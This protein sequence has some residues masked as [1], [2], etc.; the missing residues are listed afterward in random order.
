MFDLRYHVASLAAVF[1]ALI[2]GILVGVGIASQ[3]SVS[4]SDRQLL[5]QR[6]SDLQ[7]D[8]ESAR[9]DADLLRRQQAAGT[10]YIEESYPAVMSG[11]LRGVP[12]ALLF[13]GPVDSKLRSAVVQ[14]LG[15]AN[16][17]PLARMRALQLPIDTAAV[18][19]AIPSDAGSPKLEEVGRRLGREFVGRGETPFWDALAPVIVQDSQGPS[20][21]E[22]DAIVVVQTVPLDGAPTT[23]LVSGVYA[24]LAGSGVPVVGVARTDQQP[25]RIAVYR[26]RGLSSVDAVD[27]QV[28]RVALAVLLAGGEEGHYGLNTDADGVVP[29]IEPLPLAPPPSG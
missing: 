26:A 20:Q 9:T 18:M 25:Q 27:T 1:L 11:R 13:I 24:G 22:A 5:E 19:G 16:G 29:P 2:I 28:G 14:T 3:T 4:E 12:V 7:R 21:R 23:R 6:I 10:S 15:D 17:P 8:L